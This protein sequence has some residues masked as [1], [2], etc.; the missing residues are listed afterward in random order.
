M[1]RTCKNKGLGGE[2]TGN[3][4]SCL[5]RTYPGLPILPFLLEDDSCSRTKRPYSMLHVVSLSSSRQRPLVAD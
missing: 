1:L 5:F 2:V 4:Q 3:A